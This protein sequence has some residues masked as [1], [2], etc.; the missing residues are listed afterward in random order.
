MS[1]VPCSVQNIY[2]GIIEM[3]VNVTDIDFRELYF[4]S[5][6]KRRNLDTACPKRRKL[7]QRFIGLVT[8]YNIRTDSF[9]KI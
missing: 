9:P 4:N 8:G 6:V 3:P 5:C 2:S 7:K 1:L